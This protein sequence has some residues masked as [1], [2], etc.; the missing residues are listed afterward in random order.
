MESF[1]AS[2]SRFDTWYRLPLW[3]LRGKAYLR[4]QL[5]EHASLD[6]A[7]L[8]YNTRLLE[9]LAGERARGRRL[10][11]VAEADRRLAEAVAAHLGCFETVIAPANGK[12]LRGAGKLEA[13]NAYLGGAPF[14]YAGNQHRDLPVWRAAAGGVLVNASPRL[15]AA[16]GR[17]TTVEATFEDREPRLAGLIKALRPHQWVKNLLVFVPLVASGELLDFRGWAAALLA[18]AAF[19]ATAS[20]IYI[21]NDLTDLAADRLHPRKRR[22]PFASGAASARVGLLLAAGLLAIGFALS[23]LAGALTLVLVYALTSIAYSFYLKQRPLIDVFCL[24]LLYIIRL[25]TG[26]EVS[27]HR[28]SPWL[29]GFLF[30][31]FLGLALMKRVAELSENEPSGQRIA[32]RGYWASDTLMLSLMGVSSA[33]T[34]CLVLALYLQSAA[35]DIYA[36]PALLLP[37]VPLLLFWQC[38][39]WLST[40]RGYMLDDPIVYSVRDWVSWLVA[41]AIAILIVLAHQ[42]GLAPV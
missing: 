15:A 18:F 16:A 36:S 32:R 9:Y 28:V 14:A 33:F 40:H 29:L 27:G 1:L 4:G 20:A 24:S 25:A 6:P 17:V 37:M 12:P 3:L 26:G 31:M 13:I 21:V 22:R 39:L 41:G 5:Y 23:N 30:F 34:S 19:C 38:R 8:P 35:H 11:L 10:V 2:A 42:P 7:L